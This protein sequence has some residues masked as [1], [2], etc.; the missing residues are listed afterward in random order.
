MTTYAFGPPTD[1]LIYAMPYRRQQLI[2][3]GCAVGEIEI[4]ARRR[5]GPDGTPALAWGVTA[6]TY[7]SLT[8]PALPPQRRPRTRPAAAVP[9]APAAGAPPK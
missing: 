4:H 8:P 9:A 6:I 7:A 3:D 1:D 2:V 5:Q